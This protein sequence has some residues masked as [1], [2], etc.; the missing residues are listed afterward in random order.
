MATAGPTQGL[1]M[2]ATQSPRPALLRAIVV[3]GCA[4]AGASTVLILGSDHVSE[5]V[6]HAALN[7]W[8]T[9]TFVCAGVI[10]WWRRPD[11]RFGRLM[12]VAGAANFLSSLSAANARALHDRDRVR[13]AA[14]GPVPARVPR[15]SQR[16]AGNGAERAPHRH[17]VRHRVRP[18]ARRDG[19]RTGSDR[20][21]CSR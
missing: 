21:T 4:A 3:A 17:R 6:V 8:V 5:P 1:D 14:G 7:N 15:V 11:S 16:P 2:N 10:A 19:A 12:I 9:L 18:A 13:P 20:T